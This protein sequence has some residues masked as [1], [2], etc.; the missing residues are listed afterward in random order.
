MKAQDAIQT[1]PTTVLL[2]NPMLPPYRLALFRALH[3]SPTLDV[4]FAY[5]LA[6]KATAL[7]D[8]DAEHELPVLPVRNVYLGPN[9]L[10]TLQMGLIRHLRSRRWNAMVASFDPRLVFNLLALMVARRQGTRFIWWGHGIRPRQ[11]FAGLYKRLALMADAVILY[12]GEGKRNLIALGVPEERLFVAWNSIDTV[13]IDS[14]RESGWTARHRILSIGRLV[15]GKRNDLLLEAFALASGALQPN[16]RLSVVGEG[17]EEAPLKAQAESLGI[18]DRVDWH[19]PIY[20][21]G[22]LATIFNASLVCVTSGYVGLSA[23]HA[24]A[25][26][27]PKLYA[28]DEPHSPE[29][30][31]LIPGENSATFRAGDAESLARQLVDLAADPA[32][33]EAMGNAGSEKVLHE[34]SVG[35]MVQTF[36]DAIAF[37]CRSRP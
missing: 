26:G 27:V 15:A 23:I 7:Q 6:R 10:A 12:S 13:G 36:E 9:G 19:G 25:F 32:R 5:G 2:E 3:G 4:S 28:D 21:Q 17:P 29:V 37:A 30:E 31:A 8:V 35:R 1:Q 16:I 11:R 24:L 22:Q 14:L 18:S 34:F 33:L 20:D